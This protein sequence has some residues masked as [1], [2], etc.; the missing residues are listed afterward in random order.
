MTLMC[1]MLFHAFNS[2]FLYDLISS[3][4]SIPVPQTYQI[5]NQSENAIRCSIIIKV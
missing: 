3:P 1:Y 4:A 5:A 2:L